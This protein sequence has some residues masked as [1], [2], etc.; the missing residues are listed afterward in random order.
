M[1]QPDLSVLIPTYGRTAT[2]AR[3]LDRLRDQSLE[4]GRFEVVVVDDGSPEPI[5][6]D[7]ASYPFHLTLLR[8]DNAGPGAARTRPACSS[9]IR[10]AQTDRL[11]AGH[12]RASTAA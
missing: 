3:L 4:P 10:W 1:Q 11:A 6:L 8:Q 2:I 12:S 7:T 9:A 5:A